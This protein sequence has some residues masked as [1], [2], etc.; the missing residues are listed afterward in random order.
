MTMTPPI[1]Q[2]SHVLNPLATSAQLEIS[3]SQLDGLPKHL[4]DSVRFEAAQLVQ[5]AGILIR[6]PQDVIAQSL[7]ILYR[8]WAGPEG[9]SLLEYDAKVCLNQV[10]PSARTKT[11]TLPASRTWRRRPSI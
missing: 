1:S 4:E 7:V 10:Q 2:T 9:G 5:A 3:A 8:F 11:L 6:L